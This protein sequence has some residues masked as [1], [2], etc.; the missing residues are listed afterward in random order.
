MKNGGRA[1]MEKELACG[2]ILFHIYPIHIER[3]VCHWSSGLQK[4][5]GLLCCR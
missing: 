1:E 5:H 3:E 4:R 2:K